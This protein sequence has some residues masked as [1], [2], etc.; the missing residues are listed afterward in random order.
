MIPGLPA[1]A[2]VA[3]AFVLV[4]ALVWLAARLARRAGLGGRSGGGALVIEDVLWL[5]GR[6]RLAVVRHG[7]R[8][9]LLLTGGGNDVLL[10]WDAP[11]PDAP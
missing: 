8:R 6:R 11:G 10:P 5:D 1:L 9:V 2:S 4:L 7:T 3:G